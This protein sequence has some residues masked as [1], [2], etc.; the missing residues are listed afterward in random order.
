MLKQKYEDRAV[1]TEKNDCPGWH[2]SMVRESA[3]G[4]KGLGFNSQSRD[5]IWIAGSIPSSSGAHAGGKQ[6]L[7]SLS[8]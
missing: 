2:G 8:P 3:C 7:S 5:P 6:S 1:D 4:L